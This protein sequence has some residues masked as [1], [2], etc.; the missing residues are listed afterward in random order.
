MISSDNITPSPRSCR[1]PVRNINLHYLEW[2]ATENPPLMLIRGGESKTLSP[3]AAQEMEARCP[4]LRTVEIP[5][6]GH[7]V[8]LDKPAAFLEAVRK[9]LHE[10]T[11]GATCKT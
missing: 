7:H 4:R 9:F 5:G 8:F 2:G 11:E 3:E 6:A 10:H 1:I